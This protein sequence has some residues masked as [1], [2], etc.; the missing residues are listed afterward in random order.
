MGHS[1][2]TV[3]EETDTD[4]LPIA[5][6][7]REGV[8]SREKGFAISAVEVL[9]AV[10]FAVVGDLEIETGEGAW[11]DKCA[12]TVLFDENAVFTEADASEQLARAEETG[13]AV[14]CGFDNGGTLA[15]I[16]DDFLR[17]HVSAEFEAV[18]WLG[19][20][21]QEAWA[22]V[23]A[24][25]GVVRVVV[26]LPLKTDGIGEIVGGAEEK[27]LLQTPPGLPGLRGGNRGGRP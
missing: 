12:I 3:T 8:A 14:A 16:A 10:L 23:E 24:P 4:A 6:S 1:I 22:L 21:R 17:E 18:G 19:M 20:D 27:P 7:H 2:G 13:I 5:T 15:L 26:P 25:M 9:V 11:Q